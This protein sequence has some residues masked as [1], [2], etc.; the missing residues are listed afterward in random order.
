M[1]WILIFA[2]VTQFGHEEI[3]GTRADTRSK[4]L[5]AVSSRRVYLKRECFILAE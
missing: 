1:I 5:L 2:K 3:M 4:F